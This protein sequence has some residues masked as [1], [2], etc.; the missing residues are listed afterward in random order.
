MST[1]PLTPYTFGLMREAEAREIAAWR[2]DGPYAA[3]NMDADDPSG[4]AELLD[5]RSPY[6]AVRD[7][8]GDLTGFFAFGTAAEVQQVQGSGPPRLF[9]AGGTLSIG[10]G[11]RPDL[12]GR[13]QGLA[14]VNAGLTFACQTYAPTAFRLY[15]MTFNHRAIRVYER[16]GFAP[17]GTVR[18]PAPGGVAREFLEM[19]RAAM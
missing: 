14:F 2:Y 3:Y 9:A 13:G 6:Y 1:M 18:V 12:T 15:V 8:H 4:L 19:R 17:V 5:R 16:A 11:M 10:L 7:Q